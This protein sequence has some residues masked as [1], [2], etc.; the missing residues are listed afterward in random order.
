MNQTCTRA[1]IKSLDYVLHIVYVQYQQI[2]LIFFILYVICYDRNNNPPVSK[3]SI[4]KGWV[5]NDWIIQWS[6]MN[7]ALIMD[8]A[9]KEKYI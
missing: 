6:K 2:S 1:D 4:D 3:A 9:Q 5:Q 8:A 7:Q